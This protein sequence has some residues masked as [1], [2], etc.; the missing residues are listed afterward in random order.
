MLWHRA[1]YQFLLFQLPLIGLSSGIS[2]LVAPE[3]TPAQL[4]G[5]L[6]AYTTFVTISADMALHDGM[7]PL[8]RKLLPVE[9]AQRNMTRSLP[10]QLH[11]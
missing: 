10:L 11:A 9:T 4:D 1:L 7:P 5:C 2:N 8:R 6:N 3:H